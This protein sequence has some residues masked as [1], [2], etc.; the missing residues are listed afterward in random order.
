M[1]SEKT[2]FGSN[3]GVILVGAVIGVIAAVLVKLGNPGNMGVCVACFSRDI[4]GA[5]GLHRAEAAQYLRPELTG[6]VLGALLSALW[7]KEF[8]PRAG[9]AAIVRF[10]L[11]IFA[12]IGTLVFLG[13]TWRVFLRLGGGDANALS[14]ILGLVVGVAA[15][16]GLMKLGFSLGRSKPAPKALGW[17][18]PVLAL[19]VVALAV[20]DFK[21]GPVDANNKATAAVFTTPADTVPGGKRAFWPYALAAGALIGFLAHRS[22]FCTVGAIRNIFLLRDLHMFYGVAALVAGNCAANVAM[23]QFKWGM[24]GQPVAH[25]QTLWNVLGMV[26]AG[27]AFTLGGGCPGRQFILAGEGDSDA[28]VF[29]MG[30]IAGTA[31]AHNFLL[32]SSPKG[33][34]AFGPWAVA[35][36]LAVC[37]IVGLTMREPQESPA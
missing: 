13:C 4:A 33:V 27:L 34:G 19:A 8:K 35:V 15:G 3:L 37:V 17:V 1:P 10:V 24:E 18:M 14:G 5:L 22:R 20:T 25:T 2:F 32:A 9:S 28:G 16:A 6:F 23:G 11:G 7:F 31:L 21:F 26:L 36:G 12:A 29:C 30:M